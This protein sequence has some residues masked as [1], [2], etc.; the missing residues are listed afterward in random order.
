MTDQK[1]PM[2]EFSF[3]IELEDIPEEGASYTL[4]AGEEERSG[5]A[6]RFG[7]QSIGRLEADV[8]LEWIK[9]NKALVVTGSI[10]ADVVQ[11]CVV[12]LEPVPAKVDEPI[13]L[14]F[15]RNVDA[16]A[17]FVDP[18]EAEPLEG[19]TLDLGELVAEELSLGL[20]PY[21]R[22]PDIDP[23]ALE[24]GPGATYS[25]DDEPSE[26]TPRG[27]RPFEVLAGLRRKN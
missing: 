18:E 25:T 7:L 23:A 17:E 9:R 4:A 26:E 21:P 12:T 11:T 19:E 14:T 3:I 27:N 1:K 10:S 16:I 22:S 15:A 24:L 13:D 5:L 2:P 8:R 6:A 20:D